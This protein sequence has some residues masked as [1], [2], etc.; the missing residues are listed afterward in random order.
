MEVKDAMA[1]LRL[2]ANR[3]DDAAFERAVNTP[4]RGIGGRT[5]DEVRRVARAQALSLWQAARQLAAGEHGAAL[6]GRARN[7]LRGFEN[8]LDE[9]STQLD[10]MQLHEQ[11]DHMLERSGLRTHYAAESRGQLDSRV[12]NLDELVSVASRFERRADEEAEGMT[13]LVAFLAYAALE[14]GEGQAEAGEDGVQMMTLHSA[15][16]LEFPLVFLVGLEEGIFPGQRSADDP[17]RLEEERRLAYVGLTRARKRLVLTHAESRTLHGSTVMFPQ[18]RFLREIPAALIREVRPRAKARGYAPSPSPS[19]LYDTSP[20]GGLKLGQR[21]AHASFGEG[22]V[23]D[24]EGSGAHARVQVN[25]ERAGS[26]W[27]VLAYAN[28]AP[29]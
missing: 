11:F 22:V 18:S 27:L 28:L 1:Y 6:A 3:D 14:A 23:T 12:D 8:L 24:C 7:S 16:G 25:F 9:L 15:K 21:V 2:V 29:L 10:G 26:K 19:R 5:L 4:P 13:E 20:V 17:G